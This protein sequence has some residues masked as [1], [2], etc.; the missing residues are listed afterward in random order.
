MDYIP[1]KE[2]ADRW[3]VSEVV[4]RKYCRDHR[5]PGAVQQNGSWLIPANAKK[6]EK[7]VNKRSVEKLSS[8]GKKLRHQKSKR[9]PHGLYDYVMINFTYSSCRMAS[10]RLTRDQIE[11]IY[12]KGKIC[13]LFEPTKV[14]DMVEAMNHCVCIDYIL[15][16]A[17]EPLTHKMIMEL[18]YLLMFGTVDHRKKFVTP[19]V[20]RTKGILRRDRDMPPAEEIDGSLR[21]LIR[22]YEDTQEI[23]INEILDFHVQFERI[24]PFED[25]NGRVGR[26]ILFKE[27]LRQGVTPFIIDDKRRSQY[28]AGLKEW[29]DYR[30][31]LLEVATVAQERFELQLAHD[32]LRAP[33]WYHAEY[34]GRNQEDIVEEEEAWEDE[35][36]E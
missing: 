23:G 1:I 36:F 32:R 7:I 34:Y 3:G 18:H 6:P 29:D 9:N 20:Y 35:E 22:N 19:G 26:L 25:G 15:D 4:A 21:A 17:G 16:H 2:A 14:S 8:V 24:V 5:V 12:R 30:I 31:T 11:S 13:Q 28:L 10:N 27:C 33:R